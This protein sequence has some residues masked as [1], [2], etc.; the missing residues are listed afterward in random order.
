MIIK[1]KQIFL[2]DA[3]GGL[4]TALLLFFLIGRFEQIFGM[5]KTTTHFLSSVAV[6]YTI[7]SL[8]CH[9]FIKRNW[10]PF[11][12][13]IATANT[14]Y[15]VITVILIQYYYSQLTWLGLTY[16]ISEVATIGVL[17]AFELKTANGSYQENV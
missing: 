8:S 15:C 11:L 16:F 2:I 6:V 17:V 9:F 14:L 13:I 4:A 12:Y 7:Y 10:K 3:L 5:Q 1:P